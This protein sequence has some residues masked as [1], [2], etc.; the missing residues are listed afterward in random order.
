VQVPGAGAAEPAPAQEVP[1]AVGPTPEDDPPLQLV[2]GLA[3]TRWYAAGPRTAPNGLAYHPLFSLDLNLNVWLWPSQRV[4]LFTDDRF[5]GQ[6]AEGTVTNGKDSKFGFSK[7]EF[8][9]DFGGAWNYWGPLEARVFG[10]SLNNL[11]RGLSLSDP[12]GFNDGFGLE[13]RYYLSPEY[14]AL[15]RAGFDVARATF[16]SVG[17][18]PTKDLVGNDGAP[19]HPG[20]F[21]R[22]YLLY[23]LPPDIFRFPCYAFADA[24]LIG[25][26]SFVPKLLYLD[27]GVAFRPFRKVP[28]LE[29]RLGAENTWDFEAGP[30][31]TLWYGAVRVIF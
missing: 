4:Y 11:N 1:G 30:G 28:R 14:A 31:R 17:Y 13:N 29:F 5:W 12:A 2:W 23:D 3:G 15:G 25:K 19:F 18:L 24:L 6:K 22:A 27:T 7:R 10:Y 8:D 16:V 9:L 20:P 26:E 21:A